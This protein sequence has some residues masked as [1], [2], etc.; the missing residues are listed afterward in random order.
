MKNVAK[1]NY[2]I[3]IDKHIESLYH[4]THSYI[5]FLDMMISN[6]KVINYKVS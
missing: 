3:H 5:V 1:Y 6:K 4:C 2:V